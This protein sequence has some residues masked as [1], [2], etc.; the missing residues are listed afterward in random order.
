MPAGSTARAVR[1]VGVAAW[2]L[3]IPVSLWLVLVGPGG[4]AVQSEDQEDDRT[5]ERH[6]SD[7]Q[8]P[9]RPAGV[10]ETANRE[11]EANHCQT[12]PAGYEDDQ[13]DREARAALRS[14][15]AGELQ[16]YADKPLEQDEPPVRR[17]GSTAAVDERVA[18]RLLDS[19]T[20]A[21]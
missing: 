17:Q 8:P 21:D 16:S 15:E 19:L 1:H 14:E 20:E 9:P 5:H 3:R 6:Q 10:V 4:T 11:G 2:C 12:D 13:T 7:E 18:E